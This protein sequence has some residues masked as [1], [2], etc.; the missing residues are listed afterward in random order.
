MYDYTM[1]SMGAVNRRTADV[2]DVPLSDAGMAPSDSPAPPV[3]GEEFPPV[4]SGPVFPVPPIAGPGGL[5]VPSVPVYPVSGY[6]TVRF[7]NAAM[8]LDPIRALI[9]DRVVAN[10]LRYSEIGSY[11]RVRDGFRTVTVTSA[12]NPRLILYR[13]SVPFG[14]NEIVTLA[15]ARSSNGMELVR[16]SDIPCRN[17]PRD[18][19]CIRTVNLV[20]NSPALDM[21]L[22]D[23]RVVFSDVRCREVTAYKQARPG[24]YG[25]YI[26]QTPYALSPVYSDV[27]TL[28]ELPVIL[29]NYYLPG[30]GQ[31]P[32]LTSSHVDAQP[33]SMN[34]IYLMGRWSMGSPSV[35]SKVV[36]DF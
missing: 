16:V 32:P 31:A 13:Q 4:E 24:D 34:T 1:P 11:W 8:D 17:R 10:D 14:V 18:Q 28:E 29:A 7:L 19:A 30:F 26:T 9:G 36:Q 5:P 35:R 12:S 23:G 25:F 2:P 33:G 20:Y 6:C 21:I 3:S 27:Q 15:V 22:N